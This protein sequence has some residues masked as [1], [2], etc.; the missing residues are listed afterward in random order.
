VNLTIGA[1]AQ[2]TV[3]CGPV[4]GHSVWWKE[5]GGVGARLRE[6]RGRGA[7]AGGA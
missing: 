6:G 4:R 5:R 7:I 3:W 1:L 2:E